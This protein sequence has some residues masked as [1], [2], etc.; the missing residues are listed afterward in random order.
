MRCQSTFGELGEAH[1]CL[2]SS[3]SHNM[4]DKVATI[5]VPD[6]PKNLSR[7]H[8]QTFNIHSFS[9]SKATV[10][11]ILT[12]H[13]VHV[14]SIR[15]AEPFVCSEVRGIWTETFC[16]RQASILEILIY[17]V[18]QIS[19]F[20]C[21][22][23]FLHYK[24]RCFRFIVKSCKSSMTEILRQQVWEIAITNRPPNF[25]RC[26][27]TGVDMCSAEPR[28]QGSKCHGCEGD[29][30]EIRDS[31]R[32]SHFLALLLDFLSKVGH[33]LCCRAY[34][35]ANISK[36]GSAHAAT[37]HMNDIV[38][39]GSKFFK[40]SLGRIGICFRPLHEKRLI[41]VALIPIHYSSDI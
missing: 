5:A 41:Q 21:P 36:N 7:C 2:N 34:I 15:R 10:F 37:L 33:Q 32:D 29:C 35:V 9:N 24:W 11:E 19:S 40:R 14:T 13:L 30:C 18:V 22:P 17:H 27:G 3:I 26:E 25:L 12:H 20:Q 39:G 31:L 1:L 4:R 28:S 23:P 16:S 8:C 38:Q 6:G